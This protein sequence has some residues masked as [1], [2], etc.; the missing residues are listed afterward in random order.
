MSPGAAAC[1]QAAG[2]AGPESQR[3]LGPAPRVREGP[4]RQRW[5]RRNRGRET[6]VG[7]EDGVP[8]GGEEGK[9]SGGQGAVSF[10]SLLSQ[11][12]ARLVA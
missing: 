12:P 11:V 2:S 1:A 9:E 7:A 3:G 6:R 10:L 5:C 4:R 8:Q